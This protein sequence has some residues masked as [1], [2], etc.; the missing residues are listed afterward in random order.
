MLGLLSALNTDSDPRTL[1]M[2]AKG[3][4]DKLKLMIPRYLK[5]I[6]APIKGSIFQG[7]YW[8]KLCDTLEAGRSISDAPLTWH[9]F[10]RTVDFSF[11]LL[12][13]LVCLDSLSA[14]TFIDPGR[15]LAVILI[16]LF[17]K[18]FQI[19]LLVS[20]NPWFLVPPII[21]VV[22]ADVKR[23]CILLR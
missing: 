9:N 19:S 1:S 17:K 7:M 4:K 21:H 12:E 2:S 13:S 5:S 16:C 15:Y 20:V 11:Y 3:E 6:S 18:Y 14:F 8:G 10:L 23:Y 22:L